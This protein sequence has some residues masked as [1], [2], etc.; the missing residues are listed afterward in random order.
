VGLVQK[1]I[2][3]KEEKAHQNACHLLEGTICHIL[4]HC[5]DVHERF[6]DCNFTYDLN[7][8]YPAVIKFIFEHKVIFIPVLLV[9][10]IMVSLA[11]I[12]ELL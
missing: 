3:D 12:P 9:F 7:S 5:G 4:Q 11:I 6:T 1:I 8:F 10:P 2:C